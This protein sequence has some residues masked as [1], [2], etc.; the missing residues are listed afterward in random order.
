MAVICAVT[1]MGCEK[2]EQ[3]S[4]KFDIENL[5]GT[6]QGIAIQSNGEWIDITQPDRKSTRLNSSHKHRSRMPSSA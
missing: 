3:E 1:F 4:F 6:W 5:Y 2:D